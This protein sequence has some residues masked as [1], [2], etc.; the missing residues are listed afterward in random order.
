M[1][2]KIRLTIQETPHCPKSILFQIER[3]TM[4]FENIPLK[5]VGGNFQTTNTFLRFFETPTCYLNF[6]DPP[7]FSWFTPNPFPLDFPP[8]PSRD[9]PA[10][11][12]NLNPNPF[13]TRFHPN[14]F[15]VSIYPTRFLPILP[16]QFFPPIQP[17]RFPPGFSRPQPVS[18]ISSHT[19]INGIVLTN[20]CSLYSLDYLKVFGFTSCGW[21]SDRVH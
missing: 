3:Y 5:I 1:A 20:I 13:S 4:Y 18:S 10:L 15:Y 6:R 21:F 11:L 17:T 19:L 7:K 12:P 8:T 14:P 9:S 16:H 2:T